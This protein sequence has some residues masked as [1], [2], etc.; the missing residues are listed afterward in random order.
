MYSE[1][2]DTQPKTTLANPDAIKIEC[3]AIH[4]TSPVSKERIIYMEH[5]QNN[6]PLKMEVWNSSK[7][8]G[9]KKDSHSSAFLGLI[10]YLCYQDFSD[11][12]SCKPTQPRKSKALPFLF[13]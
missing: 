4:L 8:L 7:H 3:I 13:Q 12:G 5:G 1:K 11:F 9:R 2:I 10:N 6:A